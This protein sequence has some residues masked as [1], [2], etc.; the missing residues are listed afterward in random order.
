MAR[1]VADPSLDGR[2]LLSR[3]VGEVLDGRGRP[4]PECN[5]T[6]RHPEWTCSPC[7]GTGA[8]PPPLDSYPDADLTLDPQHAPTPERWAEMSA[9][10][11]EAWEIR[12][13][14]YERGGDGVW[15]LRAPRGVVRAKDA[16]ITITDGAQTFEIRGDVSDLSWARPATSRT[17]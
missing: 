5:G 12:R 9:C 13:R 2:A 11:R 15:R 16:V 8:F 6:G 1:E 14:L 4:C 7:N 3:T 10:S 17:P